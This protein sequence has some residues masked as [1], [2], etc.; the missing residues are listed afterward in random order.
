MKIVHVCT[1]ASG[2]GAAYAM[3]NLHRALLQLG[4]SSAILADA[5]ALGL[6]NFERFPD[7]SEIRATRSRATGLLVWTNRS[8]VSNSHFSID[9]LGCDLSNHPLVKEADVIHLHWTADFLSSRSIVNLAKLGKRIVWTLHDM[10]PLTGGCHF[11]AG[12][13]KFHTGCE[14]CPQLINDKWK[15]TALNFKSLRDAVQISKLFFVAPSNWMAENITRSAISS[16][17][18]YKVIHYG[19]DHQIFKTGLRDEARAVLGLRKDVIY[20]LVV[21]QSFREKRKGAHAS[22]EILEHL[23]QIKECRKK[24]DSGSIRVLLCGKDT[25]SF[26]LPSRWCVEHLGYINNDRI[27]NAYRSANMLL[28]TSLEDNLPNVILEAMSCGLPV[29]AHVVGGVSDLLGSTS[30]DIGLHLNPN[31]TADS[32]QRIAE[33]LQNSS[34]L[35]IMSENSR[36]RVEK[37]FTLEQQAEKYL[38]MY[39][40]IVNSNEDS[41]IYPGE[42]AI[43]AALVALEKD[44]SKRLEIL[45]SLKQ[46]LDNNNS[47]IDILLRIS[48]KYILKLLFHR[49]F[50]GRSPRQE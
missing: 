50:L 45:L 10:R 35:N 17:S 14:K 26:P 37:F 15:F 3:V 27:V 2:G 34:R 6:D 23:Y 48:K 19:V 25:S 4:Q 38:S 16:N 11:S 46:K 33:V 42:G 39:S 40:Q 24:I 49:R 12:C 7:D 13:N 43:D 20:I 1:D 31:D 36:K 8:S 47:V 21:C 9:L 5:P 32:A 30:E 29:A 41:F 22:F 28:F 18:K 44:S